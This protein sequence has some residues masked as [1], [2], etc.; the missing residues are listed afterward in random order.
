MRRTDTSRWLTGTLRRLERFRRVAAWPGAAGMR[1]HLRQSPVRWMRE[2][3]WLLTRIEPRVRVNVNLRNE[4]HF[5]ST[6]ATPLFARV[7]FSSTASTPLSARVIQR[8]ATMR[9][10]VRT[11]EPRLAS[12]QAPVIRPEIS[13][14]KAAP[15]RQVPLESRVWPR[16]ART[17][18]PAHPFSRQPSNESPIIARLAQRARRN[19]GV[20]I[21][22]PARLVRR[23]APASATTISNGLSERGAAA[24]ATNYSRSG[25]LPAQPFQPPVSPPPVNVERLADQVLRQ[26]DR[27]LIASR[28]RMGRI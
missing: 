10:H 28:E 18:M 2:R 6:A 3:L 5:S 21:D 11:A 7:I 17:T 9:A 26:L 1:F 24:T 13:G 4:V 14:R 22:L 15:G 12:S 23:P 19:D 27:R 16:S 8:Y 20:P 25:S